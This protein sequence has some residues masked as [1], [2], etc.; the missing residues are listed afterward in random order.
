MITNAIILGYI[1]CARG[2][3]GPNKPGLDPLL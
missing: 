1:Y 3:K 2:I